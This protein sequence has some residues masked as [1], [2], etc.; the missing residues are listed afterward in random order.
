MV[1]VSNRMDNKIWSIA[2][3]PVY[4][5]RFPLFIHRIFLSIDWSSLLTEQH[6]KRRRRALRRGLRLRRI[7]SGYLPTCCSQSNVV[8]MIVHVL[9]GVIS[10]RFHVCLLLWRWYYHPG[11]VCSVSALGPSYRAFQLFIISLETR[12]FMFLN[13]FST[14]LLIV[15]WDHPGR[16]IPP[17][18][19]YM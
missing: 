9:V 7:E 6:W 5:S 11:I 10:H 14:C 2:F 16:T 15:R 12:Y 19:N 13:V 1:G 17:L 8:E 3:S 18:F 4:I